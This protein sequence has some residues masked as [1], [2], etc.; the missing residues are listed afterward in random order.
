MMLSAL[1]MYGLRSYQ[2][3]RS[4]KLSFL[5]KQQWRRQGPVGAASLC[6][7]CHG[8]QL[9][10][11]SLDGL[12]SF[13]GSVGRSRHL[14]EDCM[15]CGYQ[16]LVSWCSQLDVRSLDG[17]FSFKGSVGGSVNNAMHV[18][19]DQT[20]APQHAVLSSNPCWRCI[21]RSWCNPLPCLLILVRSPGCLAAADSW[22]T[23]L[24][25]CLAQQC[26]LYCGLAGKV[27]LFC[28]NND[29]TIKVRADRATTSV[30]CR[31][32]SARSCA[33]AIDSVHPAEGVRLSVV[34]HRH[35]AS[36]PIAATIYLHVLMDFHRC[37]STACRP[38]SGRRSSPPTHPSTTPPSARTPSSW[39]P[40]ATTPSC[41]PPAAPASCTCACTHAPQALPAATTPSREPP[42]SDVCIC[43]WDC[44]PR[45]PPALLCSA[46][47]VG[48]DVCPTPQDAQHW[49]VCKLRASARKVV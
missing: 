28:C 13:K 25:R 40:W 9:E 15:I 16:R 29:R 35:K 4:P 47:H 7:S 3:I 17:P 39:Q 10:V 5:R 6:V 26:V 11:R 24:H 36:W 48:Q 12:S 1:A 45:A 2:C 37:R 44:T 41:E 32:A 30:T 21:I 22:F 27:Q 49:P 34:H 33:A 19:K 14:V 38:W 43:A 20:G 8:M 46:P 23:C 31:G 42:A 18:A